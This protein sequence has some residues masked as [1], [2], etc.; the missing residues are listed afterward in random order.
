[1]SVKENSS[2]MPRTNPSLEQLAIGI[3][4]GGTGTKFGIVDRLGNLLFSSEMSTRKHKEV[5]SFID[6]LHANLVPMIIMIK[7]LLPWLV[8]LPRPAMANVKIQGHNVL[9]NKPT[10]VKA[11]TLVIPVVNIPITK[12][13]IPSVEKISNILAGLPLL[14][15]SPTIIVMITK[16]YT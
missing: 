4:I 5:E 13:R 10:L 2:N 12:A 1:M 3:D 15:I 9:Q 14:K 7:R 6:D 16:P 11:N 8:C